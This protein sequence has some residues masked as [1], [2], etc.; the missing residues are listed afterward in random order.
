VEHRYALIVGID[1]YNDAAHFIP[2]PFAQADAQNLYQLLID[3]ERGGW[4]P[5]DVVY[6][7]GEAATRDEIESQLRELCLVRAQADDLVLIYFAGHAL[8]DPATQ[9]GYL[10]LRATQADRPATGLHVPTLVDHYLYDSKAGNIL[11][12]LDIA[13]TGIAWKHARSAEEAVLLFG[14]SLAD[15]PRN[16]GRVILTS[17]RQAEMS[18]SQME[19]GRGVF[20]SHLIDGLEGKAANPRTGRITLGTLYDY[21][22]ETMGWDEPQ[23][24]QKFGNEHGSMVLI[25]WAEWK[26]A[27]APQPPG[28]ER[29]VVGVEVTPLHILTGHR[30]H[31]DDVV[32]SPDGAKIA[33]CGEDMTVRLW[34]TAS[35]ALLNTITGHEGAVMGV[36]YAPDG[37]SI[38]SCSEDKTVRLWDVQTGEALMT[39]LGHNSAVWTVAFSIDNRML[40]SCS[41][42][43]T[44][45]IWNPAT[46]E[47]IHTL[48]GHHNVVVGVDF[49]YDSTLLA[50]CSF[51]KTICLWDAQTGTLQRR[52]RYSDIVYGVAWSPDG[53]LLAS[54]SADGT[55]CLWDTSNGQVVQLLTGHDG[56][57]WTV[58]FSADGR[59]LVSGS[60]D[61]SLKLWDVY[62]GRE[63][64]T[65]NHRIEVYGVVFGANGLLANSAE[66]GAVR[67]WQTEVIES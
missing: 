57:V 46:G 62:Q 65:I 33:S 8:L 26:T 17:H 5:Q 61:G 52:L 38:A 42:D 35:G 39:L 27:P 44:V 48:Q 54:C 45:R 22:D 66:D 25:E 31:V 55:I 14:Q 30:G 9:D 50:S 64:Q 51:D 21:L 16:R 43:E 32:F 67:V 11:T 34:S 47:A 13:H 12:V 56:A 4:Q 7:A 37:K 6:L 41:N 29:R 53:Y 60:E 15:L 2:L 10:A 18:M 19:Q 49:S 1:Y 59:L 20:M 58:D 40:A 63:L 3:P 36:D 24:P 28:R 23:Y